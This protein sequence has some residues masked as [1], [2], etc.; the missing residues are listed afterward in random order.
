[1]YMTVGRESRAYV[2]VSVAPDK[3]FAW[4]SGTTDPTRRPGEL[5]SSRRR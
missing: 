5:A 2:T 3:L 4:N 1:M